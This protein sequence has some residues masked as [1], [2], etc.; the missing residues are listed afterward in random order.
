MNWKRSLLLLSAALL[1]LLGLGLSY[2]LLIYKKAPIDPR[3][4]LTGD[5]NIPATAVTVRFTG[6]STLLFSDGETHWMIDGWFSRPGPLKLALGKITPDLA[7]IERGLAANGITKLAAVF[8]V[9]SHFDHAMD[10]PEVAKRTGAI[11]LGSEST[12]NIGRGWGLAESQI[13][14]VSDRDPIHL[15]QFVVTPFESQHFQFPDPTLREMALADPTINEPLVP[16]A[17]TVDY[18]VGKAYVLHVKHPKGSWLI[19]G[20]AGWITGDLQGLEADIVFLGVGAIGSQT[21]EYR[22]TYWRETVAM[23]Q[24]ERVIPIHFDS[25]TAPIEGP[26]RGSVNAIAFMSSGLENTLQFLQDKEVELPG[27]R[28]QTLPRFD[29]V[30]LFE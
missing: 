7:A 15:G 1:I 11:L 5:N 19:V 28:F 26:F 27:I 6:T 12:A 16:P 23:V 9:H 13:Q 18:R 2:A 30:I 25:L 24:P 4:A 17:A 14:V 29:E 3:W 10:A 20:S 8:P 21:A 22:E